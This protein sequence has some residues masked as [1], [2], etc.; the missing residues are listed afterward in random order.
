MKYVKKYIVIICINCSS[1][2]LCGNS[3]CNL[4]SL[5]FKKYNRRCCNLC[6]SK[7]IFL[8]ERL[9][10]NNEIVLLHDCLN[11]M[12]NNSI[13]NEKNKIKKIFMVKL[14]QNFIL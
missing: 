6:S 8:N 10:Q 4:C 14:K 9:K 5:E 12:N 2:C 13:F 1:K 3:Y 7:W 11:F